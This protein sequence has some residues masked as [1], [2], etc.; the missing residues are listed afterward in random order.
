MSRRFSLLLLLLV[1]GSACAC[2]WDSDTLAAQAKGIPEVI[3]VITGRFER[4]PPYYYEMRLHR[5]ADEIDRH[6][7]H[8]DAYDDAGVACDRL[9]RGDEAIEWMDKKRRRLDAANANIPVF[10][11]HRYR[12]LANVGTFWA[13]RWFRAGADRDK[14]DQV[15]TARDFIKKAIELNPDAH[16]GREKYQLMVLEWVI[17]GPKID[18]KN[19][20]ELPDLLGINQDHSNAAAKYKEYSDREL[21][22]AIE[23]LTGLIVLGD[24]WNSVDVFYALANAL[25]MRGK[26]GP[27]YLASLRCMELID[28]GRG[29]IVA[30]SGKGDLL[31]HLLVKVRR[32]RMRHAN[33]LQE[34]RFNYQGL[35]E[36]ADRWQQERTDYMTERLLQGKHPD[37]DA[38]FWSEYSDPGPPKIAEP[39]ITRKTALLFLPVG[40]GALL[41][42]SVCALVW[43]I[44]KLVQ[45]KST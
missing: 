36:E 26:S 23:G 27:A 30:G 5:A 1:P 44:R 13:H 33:E 35:R 21:D 9:G 15:K 31:K 11:D 22:D 20:T 45:A 38:D 4:N 32:H 42:A 39:I 14:L 8:L 2:L 16:F 43:R 25:D 40:I 19:S 17:S 29:S 24:A 7:D 12:Y 10:R 6:P 41:I 34:F 18:P 37:T 3:R 28:Q